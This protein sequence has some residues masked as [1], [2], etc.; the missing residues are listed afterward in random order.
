ML[1]RA[2]SPAHRV[3][4]SGKLRRT[5]ALTIVAAAATVVTAASVLPI[6]ASESTDDITLV[7]VADTTVTMVPQDGD[8]SAKTTLA[9]C[10]A[11]CD[12]NP[13]GRRDA[14]LQFA[15]AKLPAN[16]TEVKAKLRL[17]AWQDFDAKVT[18]RAVLGDLGEV[19]SAASLV[20]TPVVKSLTKVA[21]GYN[22]FDVSGAIHGNG[23]YTFAVSQETLN[24]RIY[25]ASREN[26]KENLHPELVLSYK[27]KEKGKP[28]PTTAPTALPPPPTTKPT[29][30]AP[31][32]T[33]PAPTSSPTKS[34]TAAPTETP[35]P[36]PTTA[37]PTA[38]PTDPAGWH[39]VWKDEFTGGAI[40][41]SKWNVRDNEGRN[42]DLG[43]NVDDPDN[44]FVSGGNLTIRALKEPATCSSQNR[45]YTQAYLDTIGKASWKYGRFEMRAK[46]PNT[47]DNSQ[48]Y[49]PAF[50]L[51]PDDGGNGEIDVTELPGGK[52]WYDKSTAAIFWDYSPVKQDGRFAIPGGGYP[53]DGFHTYT[54]EWEPGILRWYIDGHLIWTRDRSTTPWFDQAFNK[55]YNIRL[56]FQ[57]GGWLGSPTANNKFPADFQVDYVRVYQH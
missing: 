43:C 55:P 2:H 30:P 41:K 22:E 8:T 1:R 50:W 15:L 53:A 28:A 31:T 21:K 44:S 42:I 37:S 56:N 13:H 12:R 34:P 35:T 9:S 7:P 48:G 6:L 33:S 51:R 14:T 18:A 19:P 23:N 40:D 24:T 39:L 38:A 52:D 46:S 54:T 20:A 10:P 11:L 3:D 49:W 16:A 4:P 57:V 5:R 29:T 25:W 45:Q 26:A 36:K 27:L 32:K 17:Y 47:P